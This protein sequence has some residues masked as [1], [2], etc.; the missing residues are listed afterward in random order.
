MTERIVPPNFVVLVAPVDPDR[1]D[2]KRGLA[3]GVMCELCRDYV[4][5]G[6]RARIY[7][8]EL[9]R[10]ATMPDAHSTI[11]L[12]VH[13]RCLAPFLDKYQGRWSQ[14]CTVE[15]FLRRLIVFTSMEEP[16]CDPADMPRP[17]EQPTPVSNR[18]SGPRFSA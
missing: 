5:D 16:A 8:A 14:V 10:P 9:E 15:E 1:P 6:R 12:V 3:P 17:I 4:T 7:V 2:A 13:D 11:P 18:R